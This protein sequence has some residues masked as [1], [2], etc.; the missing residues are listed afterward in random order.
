MAAYINGYK[1]PF[2]P[3]LTLLAGSSN[4]KPLLEGTIEHFAS[5]EVKSLKSRAFQGC[6]LLKSVSLPNA[7]VIGVDA[8]NGCSNLTDINLPAADTIL[9]TASVSGGTFYNCSALKVLD[10]PSLKSVNSYTLAYLSSVTRIRLK[11]CYYIDKYAFYLSNNLSELILE[12]P[13]VVTLVTRGLNQCGITTSKGAIYVPD[14]LVDAYKA[15]SSWSSYASI[16]KG[17]SELGE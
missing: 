1:I 11:S 10:L 12:Y 9:G 2:A 6:T 8:F 14:N 16:I 15:N 7:K 4:E 5:T 3:E 13:A 17:I